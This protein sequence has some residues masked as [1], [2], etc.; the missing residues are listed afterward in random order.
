MVKYK[1]DGKMKQL[2]FRVSVLPT[3]HGEKVVLRLLD[4]ENLRLDMTKLG[5]EPESLTE[6]QKAIVRRSGVVLVTGPSGSGKT[7]TLYSALSQLK[8]S[9]INIVSI[10]NP[11]EFSMPGLTQVQVMEQG[12]LTF[13]SALS[14]VLEQ[15]PD[16]I[17]VG[18]VRDSET[19]QLAIAAA[20]RGRLIL[21]SVPADDA[22]SAIS[23]LVNM[24]I[25]PFL[26]ARWVNLVCAQRLVRRI[27]PG[28]KIPNDVD[29]QVL[30]D[31]G[32]TPEEAKSVRVYKGRG[33]DNCNNTGYRGRMGLF[34][35]MEITDDLRVLIE[36]RAP[37][38]EL[39]R[40]AIE[41]GMITLRRSALIKVGAGL[42]T[43]E[44]VFLQT[45]V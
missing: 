31:A 33:C 27:C 4:K 1:K 2:D 15:D 12:G 45:L 16:V 19:A 23:L 3:L 11:V 8:K 25:E 34:E 6:F 41:Q 18:E 22:P 14:S 43:L 24:G 5:F 21:S 38:A 17:M 10:E 37:A 32:F 29:P 30:A 40:R 9:D 44:E 39:R 26:V 35:V 13:A 28:C 20:C 36:G 42:T 7:N